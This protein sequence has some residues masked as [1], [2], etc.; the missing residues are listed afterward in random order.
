[1]TQISMSDNTENRAMWRVFLTMSRGKVL[2]ISWHT[3]LLHTAHQFVSWSSENRIGF[4]FF[5][6]KEMKLSDKTQIQ[7]NVYYFTLLTNWAKSLEIW[8]TFTNNLPAF[9]WIF[10]SRIRTYTF[11]NYSAKRSQYCRWIHF[12]EFCH[13]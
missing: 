7:N 2:C 5:C 4:V 8:N 10:K 13:S 3:Y 1:M 11:K 6:V 12:H 9:R